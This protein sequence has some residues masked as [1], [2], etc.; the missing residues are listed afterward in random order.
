MA[1]IAAVLPLLFALS[2]F[3]QPSGDRFWGS[4]GRSWRKEVGAHRPSVEQAAQ[5]KAII[6]RFKAIDPQISDFHWCYVVD[7][8]KPNSA[9]RGRAL[10]VTSGLLECPD[11]SGA[12][13]HEQNHL[14]SFDGILTLALVRLG[15][16]GDVFASFVGEEIFRELD[17]PVAVGVEVLRWTVCLAGGKWA[18]SALS[19]FWT[20]FWR[21]RERAADAKAASLGVATSL[22]DHLEEVAKPR[23]RPQ[24]YR[25]FNPFEH[26]PPDLRIEY[27]RARARGE[28]E[29][30][31]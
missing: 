12:F 24:R 15:L 19:W 26:D 28:V 18:I 21:S 16:W 1:L 11:P 3:I 20:P 4:Q 8:A 23:A 7:E 27:L 5:I 14:S 22:A 30:D 2:A 25:F 9:V 17:W 10:I 13:G 29:L 6:D 31:S